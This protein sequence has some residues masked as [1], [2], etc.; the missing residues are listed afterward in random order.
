MSK[1]VTS[2]IPRWQGTVILSEPLTLPQAEEIEQA[3]KGLAEKYKEIVEKQSDY[4]YSEIDKIKAPA[5][6]AC[7]EKWNLENF[8]P[9]SDNTV[10]FSPRGDSHALIEWLF[11]EIDKIYTGESE[12]PNE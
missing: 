11:S 7:V 9:L 2:I 8:T 4:F 12:V 5:I 1:T 6:D 10:P 3:K